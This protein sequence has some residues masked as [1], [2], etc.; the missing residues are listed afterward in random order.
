MED[1]AISSRF[2]ML[3]SSKNSRMG[4]GVLPTET[5]AIRARF[6][7]WKRNKET[8]SEKGKTFIFVDNGTNKLISLDLEKLLGLADC[9]LIDQFRT[10]MWGIEFLPVRQQLLLAFQQGRSFP[11]GC[12]GADAAW[13]VF[14]RDRSESWFDASEI[15]STQTSIWNNKSNP[16][17]TSFNWSWLVLFDFDLL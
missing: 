17:R 16:F 1:G 7:T 15:T 12:Y 8:I 14:R 4:E 9:C 3:H 5:Y 2:S 13:P 11:R 10:S 6:F